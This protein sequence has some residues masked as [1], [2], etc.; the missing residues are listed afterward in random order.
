MQYIEVVPPLPVQLTSSSLSPEG[1]VLPLVITT[2][3]IVLPFMFSFLA[4]FEKFKTQGGE[5]KMTLIR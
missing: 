1:L 4:R 5:I 2:F 3:N